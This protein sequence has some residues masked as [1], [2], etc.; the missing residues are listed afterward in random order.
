MTQ[1]CEMLK[2]QGKLDKYRKRKDKRQ[3]AKERAKI[4]KLRQKIE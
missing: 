1:K 2:K 3:T 4:P